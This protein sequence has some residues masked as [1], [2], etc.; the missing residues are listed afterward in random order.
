MSKRTKK[1]K[2]SG[3][4]RRLTGRTLR[5][6]VIGA[7][8]PYHNSPHLYQWIWVFI[9]IPFLEEDTL[10]DLS[11]KYGK[12]LRKLYRILMR[13]PE[14][15]EKLLR[16]MAMPLF[17]GFL[18]D[19]SVSD[20]TARSRKRI[21]IIFDDT[22]AE[23]SG[24]YMEF[25]HKLFDNAKNRY[26]MGYNFVLMMAV[27][28]DTVIPLAFVPWLPAEHPEHRSENDI[29][30]DEIIRLKKV[31]DRQEYD[32][33]EVEL[34]FDSAYHVRKVINAANAAGLRVVSKADNRHKFEFGK[35]C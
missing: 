26:I 31:C 18:R 34:L 8:F 27:S 25:I 14:A 23:K 30:R 13:Y 15:F 17:F 2:C 6:L 21:R 5:F 33:G 24:K 4:I 35:S 11:G 29:V 10:N 22:K 28:G 12:D 1:A 20:I 19:F 32:L 16:M 9:L 7:G 3:L